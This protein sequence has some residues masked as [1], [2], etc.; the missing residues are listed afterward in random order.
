MAGAHGA[1]VRALAGLQR[2]EEAVLAAQ[3]MIRLSGGRPAMVA[4]LGR[5]Y[6]SMGRQVDAEAI[7]AR[8]S[9]PQRPTDYADR[10]DAAYIE[11]A[12]GR[13]NEALTGLEQAI[14]QHSERMLWLRVDPRV[15]P[16]R[17]DPRFQRLVQ[18]IGGL[19]YA[20]KPQH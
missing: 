18:R 6:A 7:L 20:P 9:R 5:L 15:D 8:V 11:I 13:R 1:R 12:L 16:L 14:D 3:E 19:P 10:Q 2:Y 17:G 4:E